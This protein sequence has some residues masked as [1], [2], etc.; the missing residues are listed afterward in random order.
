MF[1]NKDFD[2]I[3]L[4]FDDLSLDEMKTLQGD[5]EVQ[6]EIT[7]TTTSSPACAA[8]TTAAS[9][10]KNVG[11]RLEQIKIALAYYSIA[12]N[13]ME[14]NIIYSLTINERSNKNITNNI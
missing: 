9:L 5:Q 3:I 7:S 11:N 6:S 2:E 1:N 14:N 12:R 10:T 4:S 8:T 13:N